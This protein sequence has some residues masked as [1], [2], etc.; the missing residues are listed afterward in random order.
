MTRKKNDQLTSGLTGLL[1][2]AGGLTY[3]NTQSIEAAAFIFFG[4]AIGLILIL[5]ALGLMKERKLNASGIRQVDEMNGK[6]FE[7]FLKLRYEARGYQV[8][9][10]PYQNDFGADLVMQRDGRRIVVQAKRWKQNVGIKAVQEVVA[11]RS[12]YKAQDAWVV[13]N[14]Q[15]T[16]AAKELASS[17]GVR[18]VD[19]AQLIH[20]LLEKQPA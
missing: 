8:R 4:G 19:R 7:Q 11:A 6:E 5:F 3:I 9:R 16:K 13:T 10:T 18:L 2:A 14:S 12:H 17:N 20:I 1:F 15:F